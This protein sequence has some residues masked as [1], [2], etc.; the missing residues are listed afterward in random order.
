M[1]AVRP[2]SLIGTARLL[3]RHLVLVPDQRKLIASVSSPYCVNE[4]DY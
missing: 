3:R 2:K 1:N 4:S